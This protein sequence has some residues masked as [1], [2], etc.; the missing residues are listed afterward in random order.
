M[1]ITIKLGKTSLIKKMTP[2]GVFSTF[3]SKCGHFGQ[4]KVSC[5]KSPCYLFTSLIEHSSVLVFTTNLKHGPAPHVSKGNQFDPYARGDFHGKH[6]RLG[7]RS[8]S[9]H[10]RDVN[11]TCFAV[12]NVTSVTHLPRR[13]LSSAATGSREYFSGMKFPSGRPRWL[14]NTTDLAPWSRQY[15]ILGTAAF[16]LM[17]EMKEKPSLCFYHFKNTTQFMWNV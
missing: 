15:W 1:F 3:W 14:I 16:I 13:V 11:L 8:N 6:W 10:T 17:V 7:H 12:E 9:W 2:L 4:I 5:L